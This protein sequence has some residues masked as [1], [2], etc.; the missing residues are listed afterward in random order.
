MELPSRVAKEVMLDF[1]SLADG[2]RGR[3]REARHCPRS[4]QL[5]SCKFSSPIQDGCKA[6]VFCPSSSFRVCSWNTQCILGEMVL[7]RRGHVSQRWD[8]FL[9]VLRRHDIVFYR[10]HEEQKQTFSRFS[11]FFRAIWFLAASLRDLGV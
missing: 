4:V 10:K 9:R 3:G 8:Y 6:G 1:Y 5:A 11:T 2:W 7:I